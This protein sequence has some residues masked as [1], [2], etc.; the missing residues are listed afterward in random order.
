MKSVRMQGQLV[1]W[2]CECGRENVATIS[3]V[4][5]NVRGKI[6]DC[7]GQHYGQCEEGVTVGELLDGLDGKKEVILGNRELNANDK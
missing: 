2:E 4:R 3:T 1:I 7:A 6:I 5:S